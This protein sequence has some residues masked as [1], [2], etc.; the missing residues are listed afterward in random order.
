M[1]RVPGRSRPITLA[2]LT[3]F[4][5]GGPPT[6]R[7]GARA[8]S[9]GLD[10]PV[11]H[12][13]LDLA[14]RLG[15]AML[16]LGASAQ[17]VTAAMKRVVQ[18]FGLSGCHLD[19][20]YSSIIVSYDPGAPQQPMTLLRVVPAKSSDYGRLALV[21]R[22]VDELGAAPV[23]PDEAKDRVTGAHDA[24]ERII[25]SPHP[26]RRWVVT[27]AL[28]LMAA[29]VAILL[30]GG[31]AVAVVAGATTAL[32]DRAIVV[33]GRHG[34]PPFFLQVVGAAIA[35]AVAVGLN[36]AMPYL[37][38]DVTELPP[39]LVVAAGIVVL[40]AG[41]QLVGAAEDAI[42]GF[43]VT[44]GGRVFDTLLHTLGLVVGI[45]VVLD[46]AQRFG[47]PLRILDQ[48]PNTT[49]MVVRL[50]CALVIAG[51]W[52]VACY[53]RPTAALASGVA[54]LVGWGTYTLAGALGIGGAVASAGAAFVVGV[55]AQVVGRRLRV[56]PMV[57]AIC[58]ITPLLPGLAI[59]RGLFLLVQEGGAGGGVVLLGAALV[60][61]ALASGVTLGETVV[62]ILER[63][64]PRRT[65]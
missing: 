28:S 43:P 49:S 33:L 35:T 47:V 8:R 10:E 55:G 39:S 40:V 61:M 65:G 50:L 58:G 34:I 62:T 38:F 4:A 16:S 52:A 44:A 19:L 2:R 23:P 31:V 59:Y 5:R 51:A 56:P 18:A 9:G 41:L 53:A 22:L 7:V 13:V 42:S 54:G 20:T 1:E 30:G 45:G 12:A 17:D 29:A 11:V 48:L 63:R 36:L 25:A 27:L 26:Y 15:E 14:L 21:T 3:R 6:L 37:K 32:S 57:I 60:G 64:V 46:V 24:F